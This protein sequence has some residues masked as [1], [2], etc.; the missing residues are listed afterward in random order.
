MFN[1][2][3]Q[4]VSDSFQ[5]LTLNIAVS[6]TLRLLTTQYHDLILNAFK[7]LWK[8]HFVTITTNAWISHSRVSAKV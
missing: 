4:T 6:T 5:T 7:M 2:S 1:S 3:S 8:L